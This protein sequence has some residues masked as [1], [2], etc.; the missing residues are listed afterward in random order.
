MPPVASFDWDADKE[1]NNFRKHRVT[2]AEA[3]TVFEDDVYHPQE[4][5]IGQVAAVLHEEV[6]HLVR[7]VQSA[8]DSYHSAFGRY[9]ESLEELGPRGAH[10]LEERFNHSEMRH[11]RLMLTAS[12]TGYPSSPVTSGS[13]STT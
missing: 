1:R 9:S 12:A 11:Q 4:K 7:A 2:F 10:L 8:E 6:E 5:R 3:Q 13:R